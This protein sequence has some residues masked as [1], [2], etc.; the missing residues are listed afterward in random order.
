MIAARVLQAAGGTMLNP[1]AMAIVATT[2]PEPAARARARA[3]GVFGSMSGLSPA[4]GPILGGALVDG[5]GRH[6]MCLHPRAT[7]LARR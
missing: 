1:V 6:S 5:F 7:S 2:F 4:L 3:I